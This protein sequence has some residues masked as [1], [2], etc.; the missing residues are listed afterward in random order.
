MK[1]H[2]R[3]SQKLETR[4]IK[5]HSSFY[6]KFQTWQNDAIS[7][8]NQTNSCL[9]RVLTRAGHSETFQGDGKFLY[10]DRGVIY[11]CICICQNLLNC[12]IKMYILCKFYLRHAPTQIL[13]YNQLVY[14]FL[15]YLTAILM[16]HSV[17]SRFQQIGKYI[18]GIEQVSH[19]W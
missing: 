15:W 7:K 8:I 4:E 10:L 19:Y 18:N 17:Y 2:G 1:P 11:M 12:A 16:P 9:W 13:I 14:F 6:M 5:L 3:I